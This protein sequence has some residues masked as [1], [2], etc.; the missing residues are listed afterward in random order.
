MAYGIGVIGVGVRGRH[1]YELAL[2]RRPDCE[3]RAVSQYPDITPGM[4]EGKD[5][6]EHARRYAGEHGAE[7][8]ERHE[9]LLARDDV[10][11]ISLMCEPRAAPALV[12]A[13]CAAKKHIVVDKPMCRDLAGADRIVQA[14]EASQ[15]E[16]LLTLGT[17]FSPCL[18]TAREQIGAGAVGDL[19]AVTFTYLQAGGPLAGFCATEGYLDAVGGGELTNFGHYALD[20]VLWTVGAPVQ[21]VHAV[22][23]SH[24]YPDY[25]AVG[26]DDL[27]HVI[28]R[29][30]NGVVATVIT[31]RTTTQHKPESYFRFDATGTR[32]TVVCTA[33]E[34]QVVVSNG[35]P[36][37][38][39]FSQGGIDAMLEAFIAALRSG[40]PSPIGPRDGREVLWVVT[41]AYRS[42]AEGRPVAMST[43]RHAPPA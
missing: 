7:F 18:A 25:Q 8:H 33:P 5:A 1:S 6:Q 21:T 26:M 12:E 40:R 36:Q 38:V 9:E 14:V 37:P 23:G 27:G 34:E 13:C 43:L 22:T 28:M 31:G 42:A 41:A 17:R 39:S 30:A 24:F 16:L 19:V 4:L 10:D 32:G 2:A 35:A 20:F 3:I 29:F 15:S 11:I